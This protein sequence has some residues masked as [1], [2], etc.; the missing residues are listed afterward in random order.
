[1]QTSCIERDKNKNK[2][3]CKLSINGPKSDEKDE[4]VAGA[5]ERWEVSQE[6][7]TGFWDP[8]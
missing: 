2:R 5:G 7:H 8:T 1:M 3:P 6:T 4:V